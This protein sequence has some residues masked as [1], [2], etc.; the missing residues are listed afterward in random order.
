MDAA[1]EEEF[2]SGAGGAE[3]SFVGEPFAGEARPFGMAGVEVALEECAVAAEFVN[4]GGEC[5]EDWEPEGAGAEELA[6]GFVEGYVDHKGS[7][8][9]V[10]G[11][12]EKQEHIPRRRGGRGD[13]RP[14]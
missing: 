4:D 10:R 11:S 1:G 13:V 9:R 14:M 2:C 5:F 6:G 8:V 7:G 3:F 12:G